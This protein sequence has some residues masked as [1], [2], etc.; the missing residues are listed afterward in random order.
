MYCEK[1]T[2]RTKWCSPCFRIHKKDRRR[3]DG[4]LFH[5]LRRTGVRNLVRAG[6]PEKVALRISGHKTRE[7]FDRY[8]IVNERDLK[9]AARKLDSCVA[10]ENGQSMG[11]VGDSEANE[12]NDAKELTSSPSRRRDWLGGLDSNQDS[13]IQSLESY[14]LDDLPAVE[15]Q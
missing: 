6:M 7:V 9:D 2:V 13:Q 12:N 15:N 1:E 10:N 5:D 3:Y 11:K 8:N 14:Q 4:L